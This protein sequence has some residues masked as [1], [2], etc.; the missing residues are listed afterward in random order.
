MPPE[1][2]SLPLIVLGSAAI[3][4]IAGSLVVWTLVVLRFARGLPMIPYEPR[5][6]LP[7]RGTDG[8]MTIV[9]LAILALIGRQIYLS[10]TGG[11]D[12]P[13]RVPTP[14]QFIQ[15]FAFE[16]VVVAIIVGSLIAAAG[17][18][19]RNLGFDLSRI[20]YDLMIGCAAYVVSV[21]PVT[22]I[23]YLFDRWG[24]SYHHPLIESYK[25]EPDALVLAATR[26]RSTLRKAARRRSPRSR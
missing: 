19:I 11:P 17:V 2:V 8:I 6:P 24:F 21:V 10:G 18:T 26:E 16:L 14:S 23:Q 20:G 22:L 13:L 7:R 5:Q 12:V 4:V 9:L 25:H 15:G 1:P 3:A